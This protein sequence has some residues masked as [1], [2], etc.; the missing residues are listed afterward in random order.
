M[1]EPAGQLKAAV[2]GATGVVGNQLVELIGERGFPCGE[3]GLFA[4]DQSVSSTL[5]SGDRN[6]PVEEFGGAADLKGYDLAFLAVKAD[7][8][9][10]IRDS[11]PGAILIDLS[12]AGRRHY[13]APRP[14]PG[15]TPRE[16]IAQWGR[17]RVFG[18]VHPFTEALASIFAAL[19]ASSAEAGVTLL[20]GASSGGK[21]AVG[22]LFQQTADLLNGKLE[23][24]EG[25][26]QRAFNAA[27]ALDENEF[28][29]TIA[30]QMAQLTGTEPRL[31]MRAISVPMLHGSALTVFLPRGS[32]DLDLAAERLRSAPGIVTAET[33]SGDTGVIDAINQEALQ[34]QL[35]I[36]SHGGLALWCAFDNARRAAL[37]ALWIAENLAGAISQR[38]N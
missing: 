23:V 26:P 2:V 32:T 13:P 20:L 19:Q 16:S 17:T 1:A 38:L 21:N 27:P 11:R 8:A 29:E 33:G 34:V 18:I 6:Y 36:D 35:R 10:A 3:L 15:F 28:L 4:S 9:D 24:E 30:A 12:A 37:S 31:S 7:L 22:A 14:V 5:E 25:L